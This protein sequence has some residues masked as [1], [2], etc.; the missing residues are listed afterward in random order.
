MNEI[1]QYRSCCLIKHDIDCR[2]GK[3]HL[4]PR[5]N[6]K[7][8]GELLINIDHCIVIPVM[9]LSFCSSFCKSFSFFRENKGLF[10]KCIIIN[11]HI[12]DNIIN[13]TN[14][15]ISFFFQTIHQDLNALNLACY[16]RKSHSVSTSRF[17]VP[18]L[19]STCLLYK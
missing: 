10:F 11:F 6:M 2:F 4:L 17:L 16:A 7:V 5:K 13:K 12:C 1:L 8:E 3:S 15:S 9:S 14:N 19:S 18:L